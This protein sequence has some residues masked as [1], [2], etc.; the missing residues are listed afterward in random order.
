MSHIGYLQLY[1]MLPVRLRR[2]L[3]SSR[4]RLKGVFLMKLLVFRYFTPNT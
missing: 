3:Y 4:V 1:L 2:T